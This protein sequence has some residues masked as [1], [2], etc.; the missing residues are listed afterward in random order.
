M[1][2]N[3]GDFSSSSGERNVF[4]VSSRYKTDQRTVRSGSI[5]GLGRIFIHKFKQ[6][7]NNAIDIGA[8]TCDPTITSSF[9]PTLGT[10]SST[11]ITL[12]A[13]S[14]DFLNK[15]YTD[16]AVITAS[17][18]SSHPTIYGPEPWVKN[19]EPEKGCSSFP[20]FWSK[21]TI[22]DMIEITGTTN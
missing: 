5:A 18:Y 15:D 17:L 2:F 8:Y 22:P 10:F 3:V 4:L 14:Y 1:I 19:F 12:A 13:T 21:H 9:S 20:D 11:E 7:G 16:Y 6:T